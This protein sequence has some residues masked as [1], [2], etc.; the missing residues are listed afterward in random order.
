MSCDLD[1]I[2]RLQLLDIDDVC[3][4]TRNCSL[5][6]SAIQIPLDSSGE[7][8][9]IICRALLSLPI[10]KNHRPQHWDNNVNI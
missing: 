7:L 6:S 9:F 8:L 10:L 2:M 4:T 1:E 5:C 3:L